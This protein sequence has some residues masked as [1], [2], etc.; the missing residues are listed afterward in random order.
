MFGT[1]IM[2]NPAIICRKL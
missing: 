1:R 2:S